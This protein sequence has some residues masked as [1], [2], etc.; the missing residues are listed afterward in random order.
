MQAA[1]EAL[2]KKDYNTALQHLQEAQQIGDRSNYENYVIDQFLT[3][4]YV[5]L[6]QYGK[7]A[8]AIQGTLDTGIPSPE[9]ASTLRRNLVQIYYSTKNYSAAVKAGDAYLNSKPS[10]NDIRV[11]VA[12][13]QYLMGQCSQSVDTIEKAASTARANGQPVKEDWLQLELSCAHK[14][15]DDAATMKALENLVR[16]YPKK[17]YWNDLIAM[18]RQKYGTSDAVNLESFRLDRREGTLDGANDYVEMAQLAMLVGLPGEAQSV[19]KEGFDK[20]VLGDAEKGRHERLR[21]LADD[22][23]AQDQANL[24]ALAKEAA[25]ASTG[26]AQVKLGEAY[27]SYGDYDKAVDAIKAGLDKGGVKNTPAAQLHLG[28]ALLK[29]GKKADANAAFKKVKGDPAYEKLADYWMMAG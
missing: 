14:S 20:G 25:A 3:N 1:Q 24:P 11:L 8:D 16:A 22:S 23:A 26:E 9:E 28:M 5:G 17:D 18:F 6:K 27:M 2:N 7:A 19:I 15:G 10:D 4:A 13:S 21:K 12:Q 29:A